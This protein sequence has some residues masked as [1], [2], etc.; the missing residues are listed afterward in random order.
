VFATHCFRIVEAERD[1]CALTRKSDKHSNKT[2]ER[3]DTG[4]ADAP[5]ERVHYPGQL[6]IPHRWT[7]LLTMWPTGSETYR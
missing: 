1:C 7:V 3:D 6:S 4:C 2:K 5:T